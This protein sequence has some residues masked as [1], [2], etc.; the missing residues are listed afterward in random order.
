MPAFAMTQL[1]LYSD[2]VAELPCPHSGILTFEDDM[3]GPNLQAACDVD[4]F[5]RRIIESYSAQLFL[6]KHLNQLH[7]MF[8]KPDNGKLIGYPSSTSCLSVDQMRHFP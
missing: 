6:R 2:I 1:I 7:N 4:G 5:D 8:Y 3:P